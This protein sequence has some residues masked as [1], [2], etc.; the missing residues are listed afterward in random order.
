[1][2][3][4]FFTALF[5]VCRG[6]A[7]FRR[8]RENSGWRAVWHLALMSLV[9]TLIVG[10]H[11]HGEIRREW[12]DCAE[13]F[14]AVFGPR[15]A[16]SAANGLFPE[17]EPERPRSM[18]LPRSGRLLY[19]ARVP[20][21][22][23]PELA[24][25]GADYLVVW[26]AGGF[27]VAMRLDER[28]WDAQIMRPDRRIV[29]EQLDR[30]GV[31]GFFARELAAGS[32]SNWSIDDFPPVEIRGLFSAFSSLSQIIWFIGEWLGC[33]VLGIFCTGFFT[34]I[35]RLTGA[36]RARGLTGMEYWR[37]GIYAGFPGMLIGAVADA[38]ELPFLHYGLVY[39]L[40]LVVYWLP[41]VLA[42]ST[43]EPP[44][45]GGEPPQV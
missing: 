33:F 5:G 11:M 32:G 42:C 1:M 18:E 20:R 10:L 3:T 6:T 37:I 4:G 12:S 35:S 31:P 40:A 15:I 9:C 19:T 13:R 23:L 25:A 22:D 28:R 8:L 44:E 29:R 16:G 27:G 34:L 21:L 17:R 26:G 7:V 30:D 36:A 41:A 43:P 38:L 2:K 14:G 24:L 39:S 45:H